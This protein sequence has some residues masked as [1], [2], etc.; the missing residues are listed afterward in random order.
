MS[1]R[2]STFKQLDVTRALKA[3]AAAGIPVQR[4]EIDK[5][6]KIVIVLKD[7]ATVSDDNSALAEFRRGHGY[8]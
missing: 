1:R 2:P 8:A 4:Y 5:Q 3:A 6:G 7:G